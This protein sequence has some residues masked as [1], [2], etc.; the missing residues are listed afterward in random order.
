MRPVEGPQGDLLRERR[1]LPKCYSSWNK[2]LK[3]Q[4]SSRSP[5]ISWIEFIC[6]F[7]GDSSLD[8][9]V[10]GKPYLHVGRLGG[11]PTWLIATHLSCG[12]CGA[13][14]GAEGPEDMIECIPSH[15]G[16][17]HHTL[18]PPGVQDLCSTGD[19]AVYVQPITPHKHTLFP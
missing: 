8:S 18:V 3:G 5:L 17:N 16:R 2:K 1:S 13:S 19:Q 10:W 4:S 11:A 9:R 6:C 14:I 12:G 7:G 15:I